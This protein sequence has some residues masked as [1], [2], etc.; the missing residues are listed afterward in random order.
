MCLQAPVSFDKHNSFSPLFISALWK[1]TAWNRPKRRLFIPCSQ[2]LAGLNESISL[3]SLMA[4]HFPWFQLKHD[5]L[6]QLGRNDRFGV[7]FLQN[8]FGSQRIRTTATQRRMHVG[9]L[10]PSQHGCCGCGLAATVLHKRNRKALRSVEVFHSWP[11]STGG[12]SARG[13]RSSST[14]HLR[15]VSVMFGLHKQPCRSDL[16]FN[17]EQSSHTSS[18]IGDHRALLPEAG[19]TCCCAG[20]RTEAG[21]VGGGGGEAWKQFLCAG[22]GGPSLLPVNHCPSNSR[23]PAQADLWDHHPLSPSLPVLRQAGPPLLLTVSLFVPHD[24]VKP[25]GRA[26]AERNVQNTQDRK[27]GDKKRTSQDRHFLSAVRT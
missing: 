10:G 16:K 5:M 27:E 2:H 13:K 14:F 24:L 6:Y 11:I 7:L 17:R 26:A 9:N 19:E 8:P 3:Q 1:K 23:K 15:Q 18:I 4:C 21:A 12:N 20:G 25:C 22:R